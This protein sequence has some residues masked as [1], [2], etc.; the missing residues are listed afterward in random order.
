MMNITETTTIPSFHG[1]RRKL[2]YNI[3]KEENRKNSRLDLCVPAIHNARTIQ[4]ELGLMESLLLIAECTKRMKRMRDVMPSKKA[5]FRA[6]NNEIDISRKMR[7]F[8]G[9]HYLGLASEG[10]VLCAKEK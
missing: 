2:I 9:F 1:D 5:E 3:R 10:L 7:V 8:T 6:Q 4:H